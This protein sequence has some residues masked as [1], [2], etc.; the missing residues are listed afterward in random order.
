MDKSCRG[1]IIIL[2]SQFR[3]EGFTQFSTEYYNEGAMDLITS[4]YELTLLC[5]DFELAR[6]Y[7]NAS[8]KMQVAIQRICL[9]PVHDSTSCTTRSFQ[10]GYQH[11]TIR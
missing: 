6:V 10:P 9:R 3:V 5:Y 1:E 8:K 4:V 2:S 11:S 7:S